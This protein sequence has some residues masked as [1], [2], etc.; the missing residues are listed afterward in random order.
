M[1]SAADDDFGPGRWETLITV[2][3]PDGWEVPRRLLEGAAVRSGHAWD[4]PVIVPERHL[5]RW[6]IA[7]WKIDEVIGVLEW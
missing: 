6:F 4:V 7:D 2:F 5:P 3:G 1:C